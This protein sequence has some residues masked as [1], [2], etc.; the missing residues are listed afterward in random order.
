MAA[1]I[2]VDQAHAREVAARFLAAR[3]TPHDA[4][5]AAAYQALEQQSDQAFVSLT[6]GDPTRRVTVA[7]TCCPTPYDSDAEMI[8]A[9]RTARV[10]EVTTAAVDHD[11]SHPLLGSEPGGA[12]DR[13][14]SVHDIVG[15]V[16]T[17]L[18]FDR[19]GEFGA[20][21]AQ[22]RIYKRLARAA[23]ATELHCEHSVRWTTGEVADHKAT[24][25]EITVL[26]RARKGLRADVVG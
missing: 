8:C 23:L 7:F 11:R 25:L 15:H 17:G 22:D 13:F 21:L 18:G 10:L 20:W 9:V 26:A 14:R 5:V 12:Y 24:L 19:D 6:E 4:Q 16:A 2:K 1:V 3:S